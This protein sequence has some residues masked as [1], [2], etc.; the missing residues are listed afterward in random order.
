[1]NT[2]YPVKPKEVNPV[3][4][5][6]YDPSMAPQGK[7]RYDPSTKPMP[8]DAISRGPPVKTG[9]PILKVEMYEPAEKKPPMPI[10]H[11]PVSY[12]ATLSQNRQFMPGV[13]EY[14]NK[15]T[16]GLSYGP[17]VELPM[18]NVYQIKLPGPDGDHYEMSRINEIMLPGKEHKLTA[19]TVGERIQTYDYVRGILVRIGDGEDISLDDRGKGNSLM[20]YIKF[21]ELNPT[22][23]SPLYS[24]PYRGLPFGFLVYRSCFPIK[25]DPMSQTVVCSR[26]SI[27]LNIRLYALT[28]A[29]YIS[30]KYRQPIF[31]EYDVWR[32]LA[33]YEFVRDCIIK[34]KQSPYFPL[35]YCYFM[36]ENKKI[37]FLS[38]KK[39]TLTQKDMLTKEYSLFVQRHQDIS[40][41]QPKANIIRPPNTQITTVTKLPDEVDP[42]LQCYSGNTLILIT[43]SPDYNLYQWAS[44][45]YVNDGAVRKMISQGFYNFDIWLGILFGMVSTLAL[46]QVHGIYIRDM[47]IEKNFYVKQLQLQGPSIGYW[48][49]VINGVSYYVPNYGFLLMLDS[50]YADIAAPPVTS[51]CCERFY[52]IDSSGALGGRVRDVAKIKK[53]VFENYRNIISTNAFTKEHTQNEVNK[54]PEGIMTLIQSMM[55]DP[56]EDLTVVLST[57]FRKLMNNRIGTYLKKDIELP[58]IR[59]MTSVPKKG[60]MVARVLGTDFYAWALALDQPSPGNVRI[61][62]KNNPDDEDFVEMTVRTDELKQ[63]APSEKVEQTSSVTNNL[64]DDALLETYTFSS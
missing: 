46:L 37:N 30:Y 24:N 41:V 54:P 23:Y 61:I 15:P 13:F 48:K 49:H 47:S 43:E 64:S 55:N 7:P 10:G 59:D 31:K 11:Y 35:L 52:K 14:L 38:L 63:Y 60:E 36:C 42:L 3:P 4:R 26:E 39:K 28:L 5:P 22:F 58:N 51:N 57:H 20:S 27:G 9:A 6:K 8:K 40:T 29:E 1:M 33:Y 18:Q 56:E 32:E 19:N 2:P 62:T 16:Y 17:S 25:L 34:K 45:T 21:M 53:Q 12:N 50:N 44:R